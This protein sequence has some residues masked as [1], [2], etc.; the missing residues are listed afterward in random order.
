MKKM[1]HVLA[2]GVAALVAMASA[3]P[4]AEAGHGFGGGGFGGHGFGGGGLVA[5]A[6][7][8][9]DL[10]ARLWRY[11]LVV[12]AL[13]VAPGAL[14]LDLVVALLLAVLGVAGPL[15]GLVV[16]LLLAVLAVAGPLLGLAAVPL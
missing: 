6:S 4:L 10:V 9:V 12:A 5:A 16:A 8:V 1:K 15:L 3:V 13:V 14:P 2:I 7:V 11:G